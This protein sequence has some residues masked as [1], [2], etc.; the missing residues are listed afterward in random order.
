[1]ACIDLAQAKSPRSGERSPLAQAANSCLGEIATE[2]VRGFSHARLG[3]AITPERDHPSPKGE[4][5]R[6]D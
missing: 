2:A 1:V 6:L 4:V 3:E 5:P